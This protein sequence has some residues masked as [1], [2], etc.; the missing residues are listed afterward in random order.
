MFVFCAGHEHLKLVFD[1][2][3]WVLK[4]HPGDGLKVMWDFYFVDSCSLFI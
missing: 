2:S 1:F 3:V 4:A